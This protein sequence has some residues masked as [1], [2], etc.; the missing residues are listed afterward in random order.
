M[1]HADDFR[2]DLELVLWNVQPQVECINHLSSNFL[3]WD[4]VDVCKRLQDGLSLCTIIRYGIMRD[5]GVDAPIHCFPTMH[6]RWL[7]YQAH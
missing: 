5:G 6:R 2:D 7:R 4:R 3:S 1:E